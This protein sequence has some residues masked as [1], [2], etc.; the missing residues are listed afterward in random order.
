MVIIMR[1]YALMLTGRANKSRLKSVH[2]VVH[3]SC[4]YAL[5]RL[6]IRLDMFHT[7]YPGYMLNYEKTRAARPIA[8]LARLLV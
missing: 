4:R 5:C 6:A 8:I 1:S 7:I 2:A 3:M